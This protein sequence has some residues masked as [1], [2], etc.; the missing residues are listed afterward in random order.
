M[1]ETKAARQSKRRRWR[2][3]ILGTAAVILAGVLLLATPVGN[4][5]LPDDELAVGTAVPADTLAAQEAAFYEYVAPRLTALAGETAELA[6]MG[7]EKDRNLFAFQ[8][9][10]EALTELLDE[11]DAY[12]VANPSPVRLAAFE[13]EYVR[14]SG[15]ARRGMNEARAG[16]VR[17]DWDR[18]ARAT[19]LFDDG[20]VALRAAAAALA[21]A[22]GVAATASP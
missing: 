17:L 15:L 13:G 22:A 5:L 14:G 12:L 9:R 2:A 19:G 4:R 21:A 10:G 6:R 8:S 11:V 3:A 1:D 16:F 20:V 7:A 18:V